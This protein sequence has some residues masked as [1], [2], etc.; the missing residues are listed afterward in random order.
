MGAPRGQAGAVTETRGCCY[1]IPARSRYGL[2]LRSTCSCYGN[3][4]RRIMVH[5]IIT[6]TTTPATTTTTTIVSIIITILGPS[7]CRTSSPPISNH[8]DATPSTAG[9]MS[10]TSPRPSSPFRSG[11]NLGV[12]LRGILYLC[13]KKEPPLQEPPPPQFMLRSWGW[14]F[15]VSGFPER[16]TSRLLKNIL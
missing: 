7:A 6:T 8:P 14:R 10:G 11:F 3:R 16:G 2:P 4:S 15:R 9:G 1:G 5:T 13:Y 12:G